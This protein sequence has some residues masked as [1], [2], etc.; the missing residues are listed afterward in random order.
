MTVREVEEILTAYRI[1]NKVY[2]YKRLELVK[3]RNEMVGLKAFDYNAVRVQGG[4]KSSPLD[5]LI[6]LESKLSSEVQKAFIDKAT[7]YDGAMRLVFLLPNKGNDAD[8]L[9]EMY[10]L[11]KTYHEVSKKFFCEKQV[12]WN[13][14]S[15]AKRLLSKITTAKGLVKEDFEE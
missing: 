15:K 6:D 14:V 9:C 7:A 12:V 10:L 11:G 3:L 8:I 2:E 1:K 5:R 4:E 13:K